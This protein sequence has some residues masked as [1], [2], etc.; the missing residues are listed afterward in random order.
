MAT[1][2]IV[3]AVKFFAGI[4]VGGQRI[5]G[6]ATPTA[7]NDAATKDYVDAQ[8]GSLAVSAIV[9]FGSTETGNAVVTIPYPSVTLTSIILCNPLAKA[10]T[11]HDPDDYVAEGIT[12][13]ATNIVAGVGFDITATSKNGTW[14]K[15]VIAASIH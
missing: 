9:D 13:Y 7:P 2:N 6:V 1:W 11:D 10:T 4:D 3:R 15:Y 14:G 5:E 8:S 12:A